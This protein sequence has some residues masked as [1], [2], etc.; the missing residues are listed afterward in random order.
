MRSGALLVSPGAAQPSERRLN[1][2]RYRSF[3]LFMQGPVAFFAVMGLR[4]GRLRGPASGAASREADDPWAV[5]LKGG[6][7]GRDGARRSWLTSP[8]EIP[9]STLASVLVVD[10]EKN[11]RRTLAMVLQG[12]D[13]EVLQA[14][15]AEEGLR[16]LKGRPFDVVILDVQLPGISG[17]EMLRQIKS[18]DSQAEVIMMSGHAS[19][20]DAVEATRLGAFDFLEKPI[21]RE[22]LL[23]TL[24]NSLE[25]R[26]LSL[27]VQE[28]QESGNAYEMLGDSQAMKRLR[29]EID[30]VAPTK[31]RVLILGESGVGKELVARA[32]HALSERAAKPFV[33]VNCA[34][35]PSELIESELFGHEKGSFSGAVQR[36]KGQFEIADGGTIFLDEIGDMSASA[37][38]KVLRVLQSGEVC[39]VGG[40]RYMVV[41]V[42]VIAATNKNLREEVDAG[43]FRQDLYF[44][45]EVVPIMVPPLRERLDDV[46]LLV[47]AFIG[48]ISQEYGRKVKAISPEAMDALCHYHY[49]GNIRELR[50]LCERLVIMASD[51]VSVTDLP[52][53]VSPRLEP[54][55]SQ[56]A[57]VA[58]G[59]MNLRDFRLATERAYIEST[60]RAYGW[61]VS[62]TA[63]V[64]GVERTNLHKK[65]KRYDL[66][67]EE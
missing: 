40:E 47:N 11:I 1:V 38:A 62:K 43:R 32:V 17:V 25:R 34:A 44:R 52:D 36:K 55:M 48:Q 4:F 6:R 49:P 21:E 9:M 15:S 33:K 20:T 61:N 66:D 46:P 23:V 7:L 28:L 50:N 5:V 54:S 42:R 22:R 2:Q 27:K 37:Q 14:Q 53:Y 3:V 8:M 51:P 10:D 60:L 57:N 67:R 19:L 13:Y 29:R 63:E 65:I 12:E 26:T 39:R 16:L 45:L 18:T 31:G 24:R 64:L 58:A 59:S 35:I 41:D 56:A 30:M